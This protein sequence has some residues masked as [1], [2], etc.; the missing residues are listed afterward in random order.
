[1]RRFTSPSAVAV[2]VLVLAVAGCGGSSNK[3]TSSHKSSTS[4][5]TSSGANSTPT[6]T[7]GK[8]LS[9]AAYEAKLGPLLNDRVGPA[10]KSALAN[11]GAR[12]PQK[13]KTAA[14]LLDEARNAMASITPPAKIADL[15]Q[16]AVRLLGALAT[17]LTRMGNGVQANNKSAYT[18]AAKAAVRDALKIQTVGNEL[19]ARGF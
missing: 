5:A 15:N 9:K 8:P 11:G 12:N 7:G 1:M 6:T 3:S 10:L 17:D 2:A 14:G 19:T 4:A 13:L 18:N 16:Q